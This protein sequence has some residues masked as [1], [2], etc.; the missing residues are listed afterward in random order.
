MATGVFNKTRAKQHSPGAA[1]YDALQNLKFTGGANYTLATDSYTVAAPGANTTEQARLMLP[2]NFKIY[3]LWLNPGITGGSLPTA[4]SNINV[5][6]ATA[7]NV[8]AETGA[9]PPNDT[10]DAGTTPATVA[11]AGQ[12]LFAADK[13][14]DNISGLTL[15]TPVF[16]AADSPDAIW[17]EGGLLVLRVTGSGTVTKI[18]V[19][20]AGFPYDINFS[21]PINAQLQPSDL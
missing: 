19:T 5:V 6:L 4:T 14:I 2:H 21:K 18:S 11:T 1:A 20:L 13:R 7:N 9:A 10:T 8:V 17:P 16:I 12:S 15:D 3:G